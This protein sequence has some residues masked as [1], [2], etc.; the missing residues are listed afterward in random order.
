MTEGQTYIRL[1]AFFTNFSE[2]V[3]KKTTLASLMKV[4]ACK[5]HNSQPH[6]IPTFSDKS[7]HLQAT[8]IDRAL[9]CI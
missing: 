5:S 1:P 3:V 8:V 2:I 6:V 9:F 4:D 7:L